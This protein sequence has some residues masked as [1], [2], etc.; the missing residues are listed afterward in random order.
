MIEKT[1]KI[2]EKL[3]QLGKPLGLNETDT[4]QA[5]RTIKNIAFMAI[6]AGIFAIMGSVLMPGVLAGY[7]YGGG[8]IRDFHLLFR[9]FL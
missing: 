1:Q 8:G 9:G 4:I 7:Y 2:N 5:K 6:V 3:K